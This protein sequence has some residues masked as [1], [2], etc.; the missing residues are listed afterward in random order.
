MRVNTPERHVDQDEAPYQTE[1][2]PA[3]EE[4]KEPILSDA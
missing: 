1:P 3:A 2:E 4:S